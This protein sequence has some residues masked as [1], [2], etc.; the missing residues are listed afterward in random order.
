MIEPTE[1]LL[2]WLVVVAC[3]GALG[4][5]VPLLGDF[6]PL[7]L[8]ALL[9]AGVVD[10]LLAGSPKR[11]DVARALPEHIVEGRESSLALDVRSARSFRLELTESLPA[12]ALAE[13]DAA[14]RVHTLA[15][16]GAAPARVT[17]TATFVRRGKHMLGRVALRTRGPL[18]LVRRRARVP[19]TEEIEVVPDVA[20]I[21][22]RAER[23]LRGRD[24]G[25]SQR[26]APREGREL[27]SLRDYQRGD[28][29]RLVEWKVSAKAGRLIV[30]KLRP[31][32]R[33][34]V[35]IAV[36]AG[37]HL[38]GTLA[39]EDGGEP[40]FDAAMTTAL[41][42]GA[43]GLSR[44]DRV[45]MLCFAGD[46][47]AWCAPHEGKGHLRRLA[48]ATSGVES[49]AEEAD[50]GEAARFLI[51]RQKR[52]AMV[53]FLTDVLDEPSTRALAAAIARLRGRHLAVVVALGDPALTRLSRRDMSGARSNESDALVPV[54][55]ARLLDH[56]RKGMAALEAAGAVVVDAPAPKA[57]ALAVESYVTLKAQGRL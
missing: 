24:E 27:D 14:D 3:V 19:V 40:R 7:L 34:D 30:K 9:V 16:L 29:P 31:E 33:Q 35:V 22:A 49:V 41:V 36:D 17:T 44:G 15:L 28:D 11:I 54:A 26:R 1:R 2:W 48:D 13:G 43:A 32:T 45:G 10:A 52:R 50:Y 25:S 5:G 6:A 51:A 57:A 23:L 20:R 39:R 42:L 21:G 38:S 4:L 18:G 46:V 56:R 37:R 53:V 47:V 8:G 55:A 12:R